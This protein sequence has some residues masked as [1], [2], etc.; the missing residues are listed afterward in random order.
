MNININKD[1]EKQYK[2]DAWRGFTLK[3]VCCMLLF[4]LV[5]FSIVYVCWKWLHL[6]PELAA[7]FAVP[8]GLPILCIGFLKYQ[9]LTPLEL[10]KEL[11]FEYQTKLLIYDAEEMP[12]PPVF[13][14]EPQEASGMER[15]K[16]RR[17]KK[18][19]KKRK[20]Q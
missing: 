3:E 19:H 9:G 11:I 16:W 17:L 8:F 6:P 13:T 1:F 10:V 2:D 7:Y 20:G 18:R 14:M 5:L 4:L 12:K 15:R